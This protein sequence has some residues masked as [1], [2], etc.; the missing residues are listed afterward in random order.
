MY[1]RD[2]AVGQRFVRSVTDTRN[3]L[4]HF[5]EDLKPRAL[6]EVGELWGAI[7]QLSGMLKMLFIETLGLDQSKVL[8]SVCGN[9][10]L[11]RLQQAAR[12]Q[13]EAEQSE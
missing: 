7:Q 6:T 11:Q 2:L 4:T 12:A 10:L 8:E 3:Y 5:N 9:N 13:A 1:G